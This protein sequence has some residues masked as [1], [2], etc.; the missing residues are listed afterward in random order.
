MFFNDLINKV[1]HYGKGNLVLMG[2][3]NA[4]MNDEMDKTTRSILN[5]GMPQIPLIIEWGILCH[6]TS[7]RIWRPDNL[8]LNQEVEKQVQKEITLLFLGEQWDNG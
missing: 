8:L 2:D 3:F 4:V 1:Q 5:S 7:S 6:L